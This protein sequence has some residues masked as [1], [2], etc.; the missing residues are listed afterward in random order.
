MSGYVLATPLGPLSLHWNAVGFSRIFFDDALSISPESLPL[1][2]DDQALWL[3]KL[4]N[5]LTGQGPWPKLPYSLPQATS[6]PHE[7]FEQLFGTPHR[8]DL[9][10]L[11]AAHGLSAAS[12]DSAAELRAWLNCEGPWLV[13][14][15]SDRAGNVAVHRRI[16]DAVVAAMSLRSA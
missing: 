13:R 8:T 9:V 2:N 7:R 4:Q 15:P 14:V 11:A 3:Q 6:L 12:V 5:F 1:D 10:A 16:N